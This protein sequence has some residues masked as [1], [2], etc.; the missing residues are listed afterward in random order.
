MPD[1]YT[2]VSFCWKFRCFLA[3]LIK[4][5]QKQ[6]QPNWSVPTKFFYKTKIESKMF[7]TFYHN[8]KFLPLTPDTMLHFHHIRL[9]T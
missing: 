1:L 6:K 9:Y 5:K 8:S 3:E 4:Q 2:S 7:E